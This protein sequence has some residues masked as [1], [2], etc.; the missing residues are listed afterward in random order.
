MTCSC[1]VTTYTPYQGKS[2]LQLSCT[3]PTE[4][5]VLFLCPAIASN[6]TKCIKHVRR[7]IVS[8]DNF[9]LPIIRT[10]ESPFLVGLPKVRLVKIRGTTRG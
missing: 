9:Q 3:S 10:I 7:I 5:S 1:I 4:P 6:R 8:L 2:P